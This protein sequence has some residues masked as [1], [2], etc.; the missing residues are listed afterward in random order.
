[1]AVVFDD[2]TVRASEEVVLDVRKTSA[3]AVPSTLCS[4]FW[5]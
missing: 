5:L 3:G 4:D 2:V 1:M